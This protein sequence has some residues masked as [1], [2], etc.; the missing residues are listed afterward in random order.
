MELCLNTLVIAITQ[1]GAKLKKKGKQSRWFCRILLPRFPT[2]SQALPFLSYACFPQFSSVLLHLSAAAFGPIHTLH[3][4]RQSCSETRNASLNSKL[5]GCWRHMC[6]VHSRNC[7]KMG[8]T[9][10][11]RIRDASITYKDG[12]MISPPVASWLVFSRWGKRN[13]SKP[14]K[15]SQRPVDTIRHQSNSILPWPCRE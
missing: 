13:R 1:K 3:E 7:K 6:Q 12:R 11:R 8:E 2:K 5:C 4:W 15:S 10:Y 14:V 9:S